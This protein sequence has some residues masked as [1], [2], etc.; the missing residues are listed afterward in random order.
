MA[1]TGP[2]NLTKGV[3]KGAYS[4]WYIGKLIVIVVAFKFK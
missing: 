4:I 1:I 3:A 2:L